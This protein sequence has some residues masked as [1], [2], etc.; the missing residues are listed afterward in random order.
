MAPPPKG[1]FDDVDIPTLR[2][3]L[4]SLRDDASKLAR[5]RAAAQADRD[6]VDSFSAVTR[7]DLRELEL[8]VAEKQ[9][10]LEGMKDAHRLEVK[11]YQ[12]K[13]RHLEYEHGNSVAQARGEAAA[14]LQDEDTL[15]LKREAYMREEKQ[16]L[17]RK[18]RVL[19]AENADAIQTMKMLQE[20]NLAKMRQEFTSSLDSLKSKYEARLEALRKDMV[21]RHRVEVHEVEER[22][23]NHINQLLRA[24][25]AAFAEMKRYYNDITEAN[26]ALV[27]DLKARIAEA[28]DK[29]AANQ[30]LMLE[31]AEENKRL[32]DPLARAQAELAS[33]QSDLKDADKDKQS[34]AY[35]RTR[36]LSL[37]KQVAQLQETHAELEISYART[38]KERDDLYS[39]FSA[40]VLAAQERSAARA[41]SLEARVGE[42]EA[43]FASK[44]SVVA[45]VLAAAKLDPS[46]LQEISARLDSELESRN[47]A[48]RQLQTGVAVLRRAYNDLVLTTE[49]KLHKLGVQLG[50]AEGKIEEEDGATR[51][52]LPLLPTMGTAGPAGLVSRP[53]L[54]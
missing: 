9:I 33:L 39:K 7:K 54:R 5:E 11:V 32:S 40:T 28:G 53:P 1:E 48:I 8:A 20:R 2:K 49:A 17:R 14:E 47:N 27:Q 18:L 15:H 50:E 44:R 3:T 36:L 31:I 25:E 42:T 29:Q 45:Q 52:V 37:R 13:V 24:H 19:E 10:E 26:L 4:L 51:T 16:S 21:L 38:E 6:A 12:Q 41:A 22:K 35:A 43:D 23:N 30:K 34:L 46:V